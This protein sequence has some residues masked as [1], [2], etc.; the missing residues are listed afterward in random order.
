VYT[1]HNGLTMYKYRQGCVHISQWIYNLQTYTMMCT[2]ITMDLQYTNMHN[3]V[4][5]YHCNMCTHNCVC[6]YIVHP[7]RYVYTSLCIFVHCKS[8]DMCTHP[9]VYLYI[10]NPLWYVCTIHN[11]V[12]TYHNGFSNV[13]IYTMM[14]THITLDLQCINIY[15][16][17]YTYHNGF[18]MYK[19]HIIVY[20]YT[21]Q[22][23]CDLCTHH[24]VY[25]YIVNPVW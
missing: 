24:C 17:L 13:Q 5:T 23:Y 18:T 22:I 1:Y 20:I 15:N 7:L 21:L 10:V 12:Y 4:Y 8:S 16:Y 14:S 2:H 25:V 19:L 11:D 9:C 3:D 6:L